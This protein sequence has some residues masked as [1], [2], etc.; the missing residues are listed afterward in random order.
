[1][2]PANAQEACLRCFCRSHREIRL[3]Q[4][5]LALRSRSPE[6]V[7]I[8]FPRAFVET[9]T[10][11]CNRRALTQEIGIG[12]F[13]AHAGAVVAVVELPAAALPDQVQRPGLSFREV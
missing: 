13:T 12:A 6:A 11:H 3:A 8:E 9:C 7:Y 1:M 5:Q 4:R 10:P 2:R